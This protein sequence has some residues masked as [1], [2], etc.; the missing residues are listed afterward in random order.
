MSNKSQKWLIISV[1]VLAFNA[2]IWYFGIAPARDG[3]AEA[4]KK[5]AAQAQKETQLLQRLTALESIDTESL[6]LEQS[7]QLVLIPDAGLLREIMTELEAQAKEMGNV[8]SGMSFQAP[9]Q[10]DVFQSIVISLTLSGKYKNL[11]AYI[12]YLET[13]GR[14]IIV[15]SFNF[16]GS[17]D[18]ISANIQLRLFAHNFDP[19]TPY[20]APG[21]DNPFRAQ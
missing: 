3:I 21:R 14:L 5:V 11:Y 15:N 13:H 8:L 6:A 20:K 4:E 19:Y 2:A 1:I 12:K 10:E 16:G 7:E 18:E 17:E 9:A